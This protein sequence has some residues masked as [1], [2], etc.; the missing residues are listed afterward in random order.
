MATNLLQRPPQDVK[1]NLRTG[2]G[3]LRN[4]EENVL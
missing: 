3:K 2:A 1:A 4:Q